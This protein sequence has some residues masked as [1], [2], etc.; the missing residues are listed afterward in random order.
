MLVLA[1]ANNGDEPLLPPVSVPPPTRYGVAMQWQ[2]N[3]PHGPLSDGNVQNTPYHQN[4]LINGF[5]LRSMPECP[6]LMLACAGVLS[7]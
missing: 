1:R 7:S 5:S 2:W 3:T 4:H 6:N